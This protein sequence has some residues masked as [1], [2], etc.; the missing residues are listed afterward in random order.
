MELSGSEC[1][2]AGVRLFG[3]GPAV[4]PGA[5]NFAQRLSP[6]IEPNPHW[7]ESDRHCDAAVP[8]SS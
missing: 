3:R 4:A 7:Q 5:R 6:R 1:V 8:A 2:L